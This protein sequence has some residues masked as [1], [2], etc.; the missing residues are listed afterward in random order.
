MKISYHASH[1]Q[2][3]PDRL[4]SLVKAAEAAGFQG[5]TSS[6]H[7][8]PWSRRQGESGFAWSW[9][10]AAM[11]ATDLPFG[12]VTVPGQRYHP[13]ILAQAA[14][15]LAVIFPGRLWI[16]AGSGELLN[17]GVTGGPWPPKSERNRRLQESVQVMRAL[18]AGEE[19]TYRGLVQV[20]SARLYT[21]PEQPLPIFG[22]AL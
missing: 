14:A 3:S 19:V 13:A 6:D 5:V 9:L 16:A 21:R 18:M 8:H 15:T 10:G 7:F 11:Q 20:E 22:A 1:E 17:E 4:L 2:F 12:V